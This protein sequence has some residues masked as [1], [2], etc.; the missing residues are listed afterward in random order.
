MF[1][2]HPPYMAVWTTTEGD[3]QY[4]LYIQGYSIHRV[5]Y[6]GP[7]ENN[8]LY[9]LCSVFRHSLHC[10]LVDS[11]PTAPHCHTAVNYSL[12]QHSSTL[13]GPHPIVVNNRGYP[14]REP[15]RTMNKHNDHAIK[16]RSSCLH[17]G[18]GNLATSPGWNPLLSYSYV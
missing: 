18:W 1:C 13:V 12:S 15:T 7:L 17:R 3:V 10:D 11:R 8:S 2:L 9:H 16:N 6:E 14:N 5:Q 4:T